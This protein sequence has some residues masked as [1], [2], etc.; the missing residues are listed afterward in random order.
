MM[1]FGTNFKRLDDYDLKSAFSRMICKTH[2][3]THT[4]TIETGNS[5]KSTM[6][7]YSCGMSELISS[8]PNSMTRHSQFT[9]SFIALRNKINGRKLPVHKESHNTQHLLPEKSPI[10]PTLHRYVQ[11]D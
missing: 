9:A 2:T 3:R 5:N 8:Y 4:L 1:G 11:F 7:L 6:C 10:I